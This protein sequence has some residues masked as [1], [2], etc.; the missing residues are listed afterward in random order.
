M[1]HIIFLALSDHIIPLQT[2]SE[3]GHAA[4]V[5]AIYYSRRIVF[6]LRKQNTLI[7]LVILLL[8]IKAAGTAVAINVPY[9]SYRNI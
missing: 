7:A 3:V 4:A 2:Q 9:L 8:N 5:I 6:A 1:E